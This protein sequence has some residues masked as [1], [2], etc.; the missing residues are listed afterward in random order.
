MQS[1]MGRVSPMIFTPRNHC[2][3]RTYSL[4]LSKPRRSHCSPFCSLQ[5]GPSSQANLER[6]SGV[7]TRED[8][9]TT[10]T[11]LLTRGQQQ[12]RCDTSLHCGRE[13]PRPRNVAARELGNGSRSTAPGAA[14][15]ERGNRR[16]LGSPTEPNEQCLAD[17]DNAAIPLNNITI[18]HTDR[19]H[20][21]RHWARL[22]AIA[23]NRGRD[24]ARTAEPNV[25]VAHLVTTLRAKPWPKGAPTIDI[26]VRTV[27]AGAPPTHSQ[28]QF[29]G[30]KL[31]NV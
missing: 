12:R 14:C 9:A 16:P 29:N 15:T 7:V 10:C 6:S 5:S 20:I 27:T 24:T 23:H 3:T 8:V 19:L 11:P 26:V 30:W 22:R 31:E 1:T 18:S 4:F 13:V 17:N 21:T 2:L 28:T 25:E